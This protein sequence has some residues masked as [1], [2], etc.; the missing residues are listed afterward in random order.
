[1]ERREV[2]NMVFQ[3]KAGAVIKTPA[4]VA[5]AVC[6]NLEKTSGLTPE[7]LL[8][9]SRNPDAPLHG[10]FEWNDAAAAEKYRTAQAAYIIRNIEVQVSVNE[11]P[12]P[13]R[14]FFN[15][16]RNDHEYHSIEI[17]TQT[18]E[19]FDDLLERVRKE[20]ESFK[21]KYGLINGLAGV[22]GAIDQYLD[23]SA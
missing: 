13:I 22:I 11:A 18:P 5:G 9:A 10:E 17:I 20:L 4:E 2:N 1:M 21:K 15:L 16:T 14:A 3:Y 8:A 7:R 6:L 23:N 19:Y 12:Q